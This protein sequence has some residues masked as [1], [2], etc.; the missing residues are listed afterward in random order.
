MARVDTILAN[1]QSVGQARDV[2]GRA[3]A[4]GVILIPPNCYWVAQSEAVS[5]LTY[6]TITSLFFNVIFTLLILVGF[7]AL[8]KRFAQ[9]AALKQGELLT[10]FLMLC[11]GSS[12][13]GNGFL[14]NLVLSLG[15][16][17]WYATAENEWSKLFS[18]YLPD[19]LVVKDKTVL[20]GFYEGDSSIYLTENINVWLKPLALWSIFTVVLIFVFLCV[21]VLV[22][23][24]WTER[25]KLSYPIIQLPLVMTRNGT[26]NKLFS[27]K[28]FLLGFGVTAAITIING[29]HFYFPVIP[30]LRIRTN[31][32]GLF[33]Q[34][35]WNAIG[36]MLIAVYPWIVG[37]VFFIPLDLCFSVWFF[38]LFTKTQNIMAS[39]GGW[40]SLPGF[41][42]LYQQTTGGWLGLFLIALWLTRKHLK[43]VFIQTLRLGLNKS[44]RHD[45]SKEPMS[46]R[47]A[48]I[49]LI[50]GLSFLILFCMAGGMSFW[51][52]FSF[53]T[54]LIALETTVTRMRAELGPPNHEFYLVGPGIILA[55][56]LGSRRLGRKNLIMLTY[57]SFTDRAMASHS[58]PHQ[59]EGFKMAERI[60]M[61]ARRLAVAM[62]LAVSVGVVFSWWTWLHSAF[63][64]GVA[65]G[66]TGYVGIPWESFN[67]LERWLRSPGH[68]GYPELGFIGI[69]LCFSLT[70]MFLR[71]RFLW[72]SLHPVGYALST[73]GWL[74]NF[75]WF[76][77]LLGWIIK[78]IT[79]KYGGVKA[80]RHAAPFFFGFILGEYTIGCGWNLLGIISGIRPY[81]FFEG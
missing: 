7:N 63:Q 41:P 26:G 59:L 53:F 22:R 57:L 34:K 17:S 52:A 1:Y 65:A 11:M 10:I 58:M 68:T 40:H 37:I 39:V 42:Y 21:T 64:K 14:L 78:W 28:L 67:R 8:C 79:L 71:T 55:T 24:Q 76:S 3:L 35:P 43:G 51:I 81:G 20:L 38:Y 13:T 75:I 25:E 29:L 49:G 31:I 30:N 36:L 45:F 23:K 19:W 56:T 73:S 33:T 27:N 70:M 6:L 16:A 54:L 47:A 9:S 50:L 62:M 80:S 15:H 66:F 4:I 48:L 61:N 32:S 2:S 69:G 72:W 77:F 46:S 60:G 12:M 74:I 18:R 5:G 44:K